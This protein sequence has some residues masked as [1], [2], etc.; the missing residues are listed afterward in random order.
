MNEFDRAAVSDTLQTEAATT[1]DV[2][3]GDGHRLAVGDGKAVLEIYPD[4]AVARVTTANA[5]V[6]IYRVPGYSLNQQ[7]RRV[8]F[9]QGPDDQRTRLLVH[10]DGMVSFHP[11]PHTPEP[12]QTAEAPQDDAVAAMLTLQPAEL[13]TAP[14]EQSSAS[15]EGAEQEEV[16]LQGRLGRD[17]WFDAD[18]DELI[19]GFPLAVHDARGRPTWH[20]VVVFGDVAATLQEAHIRRQIRTGRTV[21]VSG[22]HVVRKE[23][24][25]EGRSRTSREFHATSVTRLTVSRERPDP[26]Q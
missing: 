5:R 15:S 20:R 22:Q 23:E 3:H 24:T 21:E 13:A 18:G 2:A 14:H 8:V 1:H 7:V 26:S 17:P 6:E 12:R 25:T 9:D 16:Q 19:G 10:R 11:I 4:A